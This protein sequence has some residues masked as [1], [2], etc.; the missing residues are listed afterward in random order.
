MSETPNKK[1]I[2]KRKQQKKKEKEQR[3]AERKANS[4]SGS[5]LDDMIAYVDENGN[6]SSTPPD[7]SKKQVI[8]ENDIVL[9]SRNVDRGEAP[10]ARK[11]RVTFFNTSKGY[12]FIKDL[13]T[14]ESIFVHINA[15]KTPIGEND[16]VTFET[17]NGPK[18]LNA[19]NVQ[20]V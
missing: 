13:N 10:A 17:E 4:K 20:K 16:M 5:S 1:E 15:L 11:G 2:E 9:G 8:N 12:G 19:V 3:K 14:Q 6:I 18:G 7:L